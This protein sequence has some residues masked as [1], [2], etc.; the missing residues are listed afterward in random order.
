MDTAERGEGNALVR[1]VPHIIT[2]LPGPRARA[3]IAMDAQFTSP[4]LP[5]AYP[6]VPVRG[7]GSV[8]EDID[9]NLFLDLAAGIATNATG[10]CHPDVVAAIEHQAHELL[11]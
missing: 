1:P 2:E 11:H 8:L 5:R 3:H 9:G 7:H 10:H 4:S 6:F